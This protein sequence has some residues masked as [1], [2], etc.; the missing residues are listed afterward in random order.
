MMLLPMVASADAVEIDGIYYDLITKVNVAEV[1]SHP[2]KYTGAVNIPPSATYEGVTYVVTSIGTLAF[3]SCSGLTS[4]TIPNSVTSIGNGAFYGCS[5]LTSIAIPNSVTSIEGGAFSGCSGL[6]SVTIP[7]SV[8]S[9]GNNA[10]QDCTGLTS[11]TIPNSVTS[12]DSYAF[13]GCIG[14]TSVTIPN[15]VTS[16]GNN[17]FCG[18]TGLTSVTIPNSVTSIGEG[19]FHSCSGLTSVTIPNSVTSIGNS[20]FRYCSK[21]ESL[22]IG[23]GI[24]KIGYLAFASCA[25]FPDV[26][27]YAENVPSTKGSAFR[28]SYIEYSTLHVPDASVNSYK[29]AEPWKYFKE[30]VGLTGTTPSMEKCATP[31]ISFIGGKLHFECE[32]EG[33]EF[34]YEFTTPASGNGTGNNVAVSSAYVVN[35]YASKVGYQDSEVATA[36]VD[37]AGIK[38]DT[39]RDG[40]VNVA[41]LV[42][43]TNIIMGKDN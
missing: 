14:L 20:A 39:N 16:I 35:V 22:Q 17:A 18:C 10:F 24:Q 11:V 7:N 36:N 33:V 8:T 37:V 12:I 6:T 32:T 28:D 23:S 4:I 43:T 38:G 26:Y 21:L 30:I 34:H 1:I 31:T 9:I 29:A 40:E 2:S 19:A 25:E 42:T 13:L 3:S 15:S 41:D 27:C 5:G